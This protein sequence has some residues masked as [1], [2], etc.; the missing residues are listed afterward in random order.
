MR[1]GH[2]HSCIMKVMHYVFRIKFVGTPEKTFK[3]SANHC[4]V[5]YPKL[6]R[7]GLGTGRRDILAETSPPDLK[8]E[9]PQTRL[10]P[11]FCFRL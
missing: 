1:D 8:A 7:N 4:V 10:A 11:G 5:R 3:H 2:M 9:H 6:R